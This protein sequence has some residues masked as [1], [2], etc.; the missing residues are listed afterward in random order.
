MRYFKIEFIKFDNPK[1]LKNYK[2]KMKT[3]TSWKMS[4]VIITLLNNLKKRRKI[5]FNL[6]LWNIERQKYRK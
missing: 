3:F 1:I 4:S 6:N 5:L 2:K